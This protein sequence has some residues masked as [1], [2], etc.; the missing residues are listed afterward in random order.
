MNYTADGVLRF[1][2]RDLIAYLEGDFS[3]WCDRMEAEGKRAG[4]APA[5]GWFRRDAKDAEL[6]LIARKGLEHE[7]RFL[8]KVKAREPGL[9]EIAKGASDTAD[10]LAAMRAGAPV[11]FQGHLAAGAWHGYPDFLFRIPGPSALGDYHYT[12]WDTKLARSARPYFLVQL[13]AYADLLETIQGVR[14]AKLVF[15][16]GNEDELPFETL[17]FFAYYRQI[18]QSFLEFQAAWSPDCAPHPGFD[19]S[20]GRWT[21]AAEQA[22]RGDRPPEPRRTDLARSTSAGWRPPASPPFVALAETEVES[23]PRISTPVF[24]R[25]RLQAGLQFRSNGSAVPRWQVCPP[26]PTSRAAGWRCFRP[27]ARWTCS[28]TW[29]AS[30]SPGTATSNT[31]SASAC[32]TERRPPSATGGPTTTP[33][34]SARSRGSSTG[35]WSGRRRDP[36]LHIYHYASYEVTAVKRLAGKYATREAEVDDL[37]RGDVFVD[38][39]AIVRQGVAIGTPSYSLKEIERLYLPARTGDVVSATGS[40]VEYQRW[41]DSG[42]PRAWEQSPILRAIRDYNELDCRV[43]HGSFAPGCSSGSGKRGIAYLPDPNEKTA[44][45]EEDAPGPERRDR[46]AG[47]WNGAGRRSRRMQRRASSTCSSDGWS[48]TI[49][50]KRSRCGGGCSSVTRRRGT[51]LRDDTD[52][53]AHLARTET[54]LRKEK[55]SWVYEYS[56]DP[57]AGDQAARGLEVLRRRRPR[58]PVPDR[59]HGPGAGLLELKTT[60]LAPRRALS[61]SRRVHLRGP[62]Q[63]GDRPVRRRVGAG[64]GALSG[65]G[66]SPAAP[67][68]SAPRPRGRCADSGEGRVPR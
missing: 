26:P 63:E 13:C 49:A 27:P 7:S 57:D 10:T 16:L 33:R 1:S 38:L 3:A 46:R 22:S 47:W 28:S 8:A 53:L 59:R 29:R 36:D 17:H 52:C 55:Q 4:A 21:E 66:R 45:E 23:V 19:R 31:S 32:P 35:S 44:K 54:P 5:P 65:G 48:S 15:V 67:A 64:Q 24:E 56:F 30:P 2:P 42:E 61:D 60:S 12:A 14:P 51:T 41:M 50:G 62:H 18:K 37:L 39:Y 40:V 20:W 11:I 25:L 34:S 68:A 43:H 9:V 58:R 6:E